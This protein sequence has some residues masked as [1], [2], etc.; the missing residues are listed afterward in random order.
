MALPRIRTTFNKDDL[1]IL[2]E[3]ASDIWDVEVVPKHIRPEH[4]DGPFSTLIF[5]PSQWSDVNDR[6]DAL[7]QPVKARFPSLEMRFCA[8]FEVVH[9]LA[10]NA[11]QDVVDE[12]KGFIEN[13]C[14]RLLIL[15]RAMP[16]SDMAFVGIVLLG[17]ELAETKS[18]HEIVDFYERALGRVMVKFCGG[19]DSAVDPSASYSINFGLRNVFLPK[20]DSQTLA[21]ASELFEDAAKEASCKVVV[22]CARAAGY[23]LYQSTSPNSGQVADGFLFH[24][25]AIFQMGS[26]NPNHL[27]SYVYRQLAR[28]ELDASKIWPL[29]P[30]W[31]SVAG[32]LVR[33]L[34][35]LEE[36]LSP[37][38]PPRGITVPSVELPNGLGLTGSILNLHHLSSDLISL[39]SWR[40]ASFPRWMVSP[41][42]GAHG[43]PPL[44]YTKVCLADTT[45]LPS[46]VVLVL[47][48]GEA[49]KVEAAIEG[50]SKV[51]RAIIRG[52]EAFPKA[53]LPSEQYVK[54]EL[55]EKAKLVEALEEKSSGKQVESAPRTRLS[56]A[57]GYDEIERK[58]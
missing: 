34:F 41:T 30:G 19:S 25:G 6:M 29:I 52:F 37:F 58:A 14:T 48:V 36:I 5:G 15:L 39:L 55:Y 26:G 8:Y 13:A 42:D 3:V 9:A 54:T 43:A 49:K 56:R 17:H 57:A 33:G 28:S 40:E 2:S 50:D 53:E 16:M 4:S 32:T 27:R 38:P 22:G 10:R 1:D 18:R 21:A 24:L 51:R 20:L 47:I 11:V 31:R 46:L 45:L 7:W 44:G 35:S 23:D 12:D